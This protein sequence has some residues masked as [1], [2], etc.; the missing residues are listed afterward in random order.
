LDALFRD[1]TLST[2]KRGEAMPVEYDQDA[3]VEH[4]KVVESGMFDLIA[5]PDH[6]ITGEYVA[7]RFS[8][9]VYEVI[10]DRR[11][12]I[13]V[14]FTKDGRIVSREFTR[15]DV[16]SMNG[17]GKAIYQIVLP[18]SSIEIDKTGHAISSYDMRDVPRI[19]RG[20]SEE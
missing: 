20:K 19:L 1:G 13:L 11:E 10:E 12:T 14:G 3:P 9:K 18:Y 2:N 4:K 17:Y 8:D 5:Q 15:N 16:R 7:S 6:Y